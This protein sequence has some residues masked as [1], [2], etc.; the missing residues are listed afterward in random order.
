[1]A[2]LL[3]GNIRFVRVQ[4]PGVR[5]VTTALL[6]SCPQDQPAGYFGHKFLPRN[7]KWYDRIPVDTSD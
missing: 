3:P 2:A 4:F 1:V 7:L 5:G 6:T